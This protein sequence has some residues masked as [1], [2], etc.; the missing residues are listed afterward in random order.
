MDSLPDKTSAVTLNIEV[1]TM[2][3]LSISFHSSVD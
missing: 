2:P 1:I 3:N